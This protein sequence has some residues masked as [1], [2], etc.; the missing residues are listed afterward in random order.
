MLYV[1]VTYITVIFIAFVF[2]PEHVPAG[3]RPSTKIEK[4]EVKH[5]CDDDDIDKLVDE[6]LKDV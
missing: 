4:K 3:K 2:L 6:L 1:V 5:P